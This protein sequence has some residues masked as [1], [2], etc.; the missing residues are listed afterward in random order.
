MLRQSPQLRS[1]EL[2]VKNHRVVND[3]EMA[4]F[5]AQKHWNVEAPDL[6]W[7]GSSPLIFPIEFPANLTDLTL[8]AN[9]DYVRFPLGSHLCAVISN[10]LLPNLVRF[11]CRISNICPEALQVP[12]DGPQLKLKE[13]II[14]LD[15][16][17][18]PVRRQSWNRKGARP[19]HQDPPDDTSAILKLR[20]ELETKL[21]KLLTRMKNPEI[22]RLVHNH[23]ELTPYMYRKWALDV[24]T[25]KRIK[26]QLHRDNDASGDLYP[27]K[28]SQWA[29]K[30]NRQDAR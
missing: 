13:V 2:K 24:L 25:G 15:L 26:T 30:S 11:R 7:T 19:C 3:Q 18:S 6:F 4:Y 20:K 5:S 10:Q 8:D 9:L 16:P 29:R 21:K 1:L 22:V 14:V 27:H 23:Y 28:W 17:E 12:T